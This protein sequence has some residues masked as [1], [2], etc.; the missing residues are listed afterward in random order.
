MRIEEG[1]RQEFIDITKRAAVGSHRVLNVFL[2]VLLLHLIN[3][4][5]HQASY[6]DLKKM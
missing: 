6:R 3:Y 1:R 4:P 2:Q 5:R